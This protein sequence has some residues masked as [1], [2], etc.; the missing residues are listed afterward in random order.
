MEDKNNIAYLTNR[1]INNKLTPEESKV[2]D[3]LLLDDNNA[4][5]FKNLVKDDY[6][7][8][9]TEIDFN[10]SS[11]LF[12]TLK[13]IEVEKEQKSKVTIFK[14][15]AVV[16]FCIGLSVFLYTYNNGVNN[17]PSKGYVTTKNVELILENG[18][19]QILEDAFKDSIVGKSNSAIGYVNNKQIN[20]LPKNA[21]KEVFNTIKVPYGKK[22]QV[23]LSD[24]T[25]VDL[26]SGTTIKYPVSFVKGYSRKVYL[27]GE[28]FFNVA[29]DKEHKFIVNTD[30]INVEV[31]GTQFN[32]SS[33]ED[34]ALIKTTLI[35][36]SVRISQSL[37][38]D[39]VLL[40]PKEQSIWNKKLNTNSKQTVNTNLYTSW[41]KGE[42]LFKNRSFLE[43]VKKLERSYD[44]KI[45]GF[46]KKLSDEKLTASFKNETIEQIMNYLSEAYDFNYTIEGGEI[47][48]KTK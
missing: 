19:K 27:T 8:T 14:Y 40:R 24:G 26:N 5:F 17:K 47:N 12:K 34:D 11:S 4:T 9:L 37:T 35:K 1:F 28:A 3:E 7:F 16:A 25:K 41:R 21:N 39:N 31:L 20:Y 33:Y 10:A 46:T 6:L 13:E 32:V 2:L 38:K 42:L 36:G 30:N 29:H 44:V 22:F 23:V 18:R 43:I 45:N 15:A 48:I